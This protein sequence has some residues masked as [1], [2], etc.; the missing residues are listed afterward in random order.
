[1][2]PYDT[3]ANGQVNAFDQ[4]FITPFIGST[5]GGA[6]GSGKPCASCGGGEPTGAGA[7]GPC[8]GL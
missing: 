2:N 7:I 8:F 6:G 3:N 1:V 4:S 5:A